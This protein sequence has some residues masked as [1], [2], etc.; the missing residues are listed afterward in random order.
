M[1]DIF[2]FQFVDRNNE[3]EQIYNFINSESNKILI[4]TGESGIGKSRLIHHV[5][6]QQK[7]R[8]SNCNYK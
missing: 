7:K 6:E 3:K 8:I 1:K 4:I 5:S 2:N